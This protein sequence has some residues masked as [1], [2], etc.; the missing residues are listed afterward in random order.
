MTKSRGSWYSAYT[1]NRYNKLWFVNS[2]ESHL[3]IAIYLL[4]MYYKIFSSSLIVAGHMYLKIWSGLRRG[5]YLLEWAEKIQF[6]KS[7]NPDYRDLSW[8]SSNPPVQKELEKN[9]KKHCYWATKF[10]LLPKARW[11]EM[12]SIFQEI[13][14]PITQSTWLNYMFEWYYSTTFLEGKGVRGSLRG[15]RADPRKWPI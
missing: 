15:S 12:G 1:K 4:L 13:P 9:L 10:S 11:A 14:L 2:V 5:H 8:N 3:H 6:K 7:S